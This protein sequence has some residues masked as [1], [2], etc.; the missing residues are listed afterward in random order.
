MGKLALQ[1]VPPSVEYSTVPPVPVTVPA[2]IEPPLTIQLVQVLFTIANV[3]VG[4]EGVVQVPATVVTLLV[5][6]EVAVLTLQL[7][8]VS[9][10]IALVWL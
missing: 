4:A 8:R 6:L 2:P 5:G 3:P 7:Q 9:T 1:V 10:V